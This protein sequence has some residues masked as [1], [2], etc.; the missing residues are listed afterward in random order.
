MPID[1]IPGL[2]FGIDKKG[3]GREEELEP[4][5]DSFDSPLG[6]MSV[7]EKLGKPDGGLGFFPLLTGD[8]CSR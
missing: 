3:G 1:E 5:D 7:T 4:E 2:F 8:S 6:K